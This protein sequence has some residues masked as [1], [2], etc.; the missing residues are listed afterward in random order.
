VL[1]ERTRQTAEE[2]CETW[3]KLARLAAVFVLA[4]LCAMPASGQHEP[5][6]SD[7]AAAPAHSAPVSDEEVAEG[8]TDEGQHGESLWAF[9]GKIFNFAVL[10]GTLVYLLRKPMA[11]YFSRRGSQIRSDLET[12]EAMKQTAAQQ[13][14]EINAKLQRLPAEL[15]ALRARGSQEIAAEEARIATDAEAE[16][17]RLLEQT[18]REIDLQLRLARRELLNHA[19]DLAVAVARERIRQQITDRDQLALVDRY[20][21]RVNAGD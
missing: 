9:A 15:D 5:P 7:H 11:A 14:A 18:R 21:S 4:A 1:S 8:H 10:A 12:A 19:A 2:A 6:A 13:I 17:T 20:L 3:R 16:R